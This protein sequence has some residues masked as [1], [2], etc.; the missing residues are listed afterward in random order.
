LVVPPS[1]PCDLHSF[2]TRRSSDLPG[3]P[4]SPCPKTA[5]PPSAPKVGAVSSDFSRSGRPRRRGSGQKLQQVLPREG[6][7]GGGLSDGRLGDGALSLLQ[8][9]DPL[10]DRALC[11]QTMDEDG[12][13]LADA[14]SPVGRLVLGRRIPPRVEEEDVVGGGQVEARSPRLQ[15][16]EENR[17]TV[18]RLK[19]RNHAAPVHGGAIEPQERD[20]RLPQP[21]L[22]EVEE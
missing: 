2:P 10:L 5:P 19:G 13:L 4:A 3:P 8:L 7:G 11:H 15:G 18:L 20:P 12:P 22:H 14:M 6:G 21:R 9:E 16:G 1:L 17:R